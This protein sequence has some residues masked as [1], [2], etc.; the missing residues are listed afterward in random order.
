[1]KLISLP[2]FGLVSKPMP[3]TYKSPLRIL[4]GTYR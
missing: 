2:G 3:C 1:M 4:C